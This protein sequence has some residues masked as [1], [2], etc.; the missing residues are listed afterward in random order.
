MPIDFPN[1]PALNDSF[2]SGGKTW[3]YNGTAW[4]LAVGTTVL[5]D[6]SVTAAKIADDAVTTVK[7]LNSA[8]TADKL[9]NNAV[10]TNKILNGAVTAEKLAEGAGGSPPDDGDA[11]IGSQV[12]S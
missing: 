10:T 3:R 12:F 8:V 7:I 9:A 5:T 2:T 6:G 4:E 11:I 1:S